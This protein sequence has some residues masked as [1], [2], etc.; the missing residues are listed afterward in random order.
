VISDVLKECGAPS[1]FE[2]QGPTQCSQTVSYCTK[3]EYSIVPPSEHLLSQRYFLFLPLT[4]H[5][6]FEQKKLGIFLYINI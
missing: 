6:Q 3:P 2:T 1:S 5:F 4:P